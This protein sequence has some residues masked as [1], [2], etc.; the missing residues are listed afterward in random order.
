MGFTLIRVPFFLE[1]DYPE[2]EDFEETNRVRLHRKWGS[3]E[4]FEAQKKRHGLKERGEAVGIPRFDLDRI[5][6][7]TMAS[8]RLVQWVT[9]TLGINA[10]ESLYADLNS[11]HFERGRKLN[12][13]EMLVGAAERVGADAGAARAFLESDEGREQIAAAQGLLG[14]MGVS[15]IPTLLLGG[16]W[17]LPSGAIGADAIVSAFREL[18]AQGGA[19][20]SFFGDVLGIPERVMDETL[21]LE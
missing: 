9:R 20:A 3:E 5:A 1:P 10:A 16:K 11:L 19:T 8:H 2:S 12:D 7:S 21:A 14:R 6:S 13:R 18:E 17:A 15:G 4:G